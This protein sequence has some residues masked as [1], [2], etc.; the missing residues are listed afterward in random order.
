MFSGEVTELLIWL[1]PLLAAAGVLA[2]LLAGLLGVGGG[3]IVVPAL[4]LI[5]GYLD[6]ELAVRM[7]LAVGTSLATMIPTSIRS[8][9]A[10]NARG[11]F[12]ATIFWQWVPAM[13]VGVLSGAWIASQVNFVVLVGLFGC[14]AL[15]V[16]LYMAFA[17]A[18]W[19]IADKPPG[20]LWRQPLAA[21]I[22]CIS[23]MMGIGG[24]TF[25][26]PVLTLFGLPIHRAVGTAAGLGMVIAIPGMLG[27]IA[28]GWN[29]S[30]LPPFSLG[31]VSW[32]AFLLLSPATILAAPWGARLAHSL[33][34]KT[35]R[36]VF[37]VFLGVTSMRMLWDIATL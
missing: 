8:V 31:Y 33:S 18:E 9:R 11:A 28:G 30:G 12:D 3:V 37:A 10:H 1:V 4:Y 36:R 25:S 21:M 35:L 16:A 27:F 13:A 14:V 29:S 15:I 23:S 34:P 32:L 24:G 20:K 2:G 6:V 19:K 26:V 5:F 17:D 7:H 22:G